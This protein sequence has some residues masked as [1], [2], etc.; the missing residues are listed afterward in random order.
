MLSKNLELVIYRAISLAYQFRHEYVT[1]EHLFLALAEDEEICGILVNCGAN[2]ELLRNNL[3]NF[4]NYDFS[5]I[6]LHSM[7]EIKSTDKFR[8]VLQRAMFYACGNGN[9][10][11]STVHVLLQI[12]SENDSHGFYFL[13]E[14][15]VSSIDIVNFIHNEIVISNSRDAGNSYSNEISF[16]SSI[17]SQDLIQGKSNK[18][19]D[20]LSS[21]CVNLNDKARQGKIDILV[22]RDQEI[23]RTI[24]ILI[25]RTKNNP[26]Y[27][28]EPGVGKTAIVEGLALRIV[29]GQVP[30]VLKDNMILA[31]D[32]GS[33]LAGTRYR[34]D[35]EER[36]RMIIQ[37]IEGRPDVILFIDEVHTIIGAGATNGGS[38]DASNLLKPALARGL[39]CCIGATTHKEY[40]RY[41]SKDRALDRRFDKIVIEESSVESTVEILQGL[42]PYYEK[43]H[44]VQYSNDAI[45]AAAVLSDRYIHNEAMP[46]K[47][48]D[49]MDS[50]GSYS[51]MKANK[52]QNI[53]SQDITDTVARMIRIPCNKIA[54]DDNNKLKTLENSLRQTVFGQDEAIAVLVS[55]IKLAKAELRNPNRPLGCHIFYGP[56]GVG[57]TE[58]AKQFASHMNM[59][60]V[61]I[62]MSEYME[63]HS[64]SRMV[65]SPPGYVG[66]EQGGLLT[67][68]VAENPYCVL[69]LDETEKAHR[70][71]LNIMLQIMDYGVLTDSNG[72]KVSFRNAVIIMTTN[73]GVEDFHST[74]VGFE[75]VF[76]DSG[77]MKVLE[78]AFT[79]EF[80]NRIDS[81]IK[82]KSLDEQL[83]F[84]II[85]KFIVDL[86]KQLAAHQVKLNL[87]QAAKKFLMKSYEHK[88]GVRHVERFIVDQVKKKL[89]HDIISN[90]LPKGSKVNLSTKGD[91]LKFDYTY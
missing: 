86:N 28:G 63:P 33:L 85:D 21:Y 5:V 11:V 47:A 30:N 13:G 27:V 81:I 66:H 89:A 49:V 83:I 91:K 10:E 80:L 52:K 90:I 88:Y 45:K 71:V 6:T 67:D 23:E 73:A 17:A 34:G 42:R 62:D 76:T 79:P 15:S 35:F 41:L 2:I 24:E 3:Y 43:Y 65:G 46:D 54:L 58:L 22:G 20:F 64:V 55:S 87:D 48:V 74:P 51:K 56:T 84:S 75:N 18:N 72:R 68:S 26:L 14:Q 31:L 50:A 1:L 9:D 36:M 29:Q 25:R 12:V 69:L 39:F 4:L 32:M 19:H 8:Q 7:D 16:L 38:I 70:D 82:F 53:A 40:T 59:R 60:L 44:N 78:T 61:R 77:S 57:K 37:D